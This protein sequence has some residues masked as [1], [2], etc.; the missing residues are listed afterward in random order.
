MPEKKHIIL[1]DCDADE[2]MSFKKACT[3][4][5]GCDFEIMTAVSNLYHGSLTKRLLR[6]FSYFSFPFSV[7]LK[8]KTISTLIGWQQFHAIN[9]AFYCAIFHVSVFPRI[10]VVN[11]TYKEKKGLLGKI[12]KKYI[13][14]VLRSGYIS[15][16][17]VLSQNYAEAM[18]NTFKIPNK[19]DFIVTPFGIPDNYNEWLGLKCDITDFVL[20]LGRSNRDFDFLAKVWNQKC[21]QKRKLVIISDT[22]NPTSSLPSN[23]IHLSNIK[24]NETY[25][26]IANC[27]MSIISIKESN[28]C[29]GDT[30]LL[31]SMMM[32][33]PVIITAPSTL[34]EMYVI[35][36]VNGV[37]IPKEPAK[38]AEIIATTLENEDFMRKL[39]ETARESY[40]N[41]FSRFSMGHKLISHLS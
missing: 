9:F 17:H 19:T 11:F 26:Y 29:S 6:Y 12:Y 2:I 25:S 4:E 1:T 7:F 40:L 34:S 31:N 21:L 5:S 27:T 37:H 8:R 15:K 36:G 3:E 14:Y 33:K 10:I 38:A 28:L 16:I 18:R 20:S 39:S 30:V 13:D 22:W 32:A 35:D 23:I 41:N 24:V